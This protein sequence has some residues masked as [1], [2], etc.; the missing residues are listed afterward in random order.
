MKEQNFE[1]R[2]QQE[3][4]DVEQRLSAYFGPPLP[5]QPLSSDSWQKLRYRLA[6][7]EDAGRRRCNHLPRRRSQAHVSIAL[8]DA[9]ARIVYRAGVAYPPPKLLCM[10]KLRLRE[11]SVRISWLGRRAIR[12][13]LPINAM[14]SMGQDEL[15]VLLATGL[16][17]SITARKPKYMLGRLLLAG[18]ALLACLTLILSWIHHALLIGLPLAVVLC[19]LVVVVWQLQ[20]RSIAFRADTLMVRWLGRSRACSGLHALADRSR[21][22]RRRRWGEPSLVERIQRV[23]GTRVEAR[24]HELTLVG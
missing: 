5:E 8:Q 17:R 16:A 23:C 12:L 6:P 7:R 15:D 11:P 21:T 10:L 9:F 22:P 1:K 20:T 18:V 24:D 14:T 3:P 13:L 4:V 19:A 2:K